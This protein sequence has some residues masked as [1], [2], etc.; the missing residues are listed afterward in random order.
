MSDEEII[1]KYNKCVNQMEFVTTEDWGQD[2]ENVF[3]AA[4]RKGHADGYADGTRKTSD[5]NQ[6]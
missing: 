3:V 1:K 4:Y 5:D 2:M 6:S